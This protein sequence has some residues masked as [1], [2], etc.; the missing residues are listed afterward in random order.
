MSNVVPFPEPAVEAACDLEA[1]IAPL[2]TAALET[3]VGK[4]E[5]EL[6]ARAAAIAEGRCEARQIAAVQVEIGE[7]L[8][9][10]A[11]T[12]ENYRISFHPA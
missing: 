11:R 4:I 3:I 1:A 5:A 2:I 6:R 10:V 7:L 12:H 9:A 8:L